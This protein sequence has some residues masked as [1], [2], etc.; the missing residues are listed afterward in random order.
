MNLGKAITGEYDSFINIW[1]IFPAFADKT[2]TTVKHYLALSSASVENILRLN[3]FIPRVLRFKYK[4]SEPS[5][6]FG[7][8]N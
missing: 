1:T 3:N 8:Q 4:N 6:R 2:N 5:A 7:A